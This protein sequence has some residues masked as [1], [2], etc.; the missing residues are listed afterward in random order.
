MK[1]LV[2]N[3]SPSGDNS[4]TLQ[5]VRYIKKLFPEHRYFL[6]NA[7]QRIKS[8]E[9]DFSPAV[10]ALSGADMIVFCYPVYTFLAPAQLHRFIELLKESGTDVSGKC[11]TQITTSKHFYDVTAHRFIMENCMDLGLNYITGLSADMEDLLHEKGQRE[12]EAFFRRTLWAAGN[13]VFE[14][15]NAAP[16]AADRLQRASLPERETVKKDRGRVVIVTD[17]DSSGSALDSM[18]ERFIRVCPYSCSVVNLRDF[19]FAGGC[20]GCFRCA[21][22]GTCIYKD[23]FDV[24]L[25][26]SIQTA[27]ATVYAFTIKDHSMGYRFKLYDDRQF[28]NGH[29]TVTM[30]RPVGYIVDGELSRQPGLRQLMEARAQV[31]GNYLARTACN[32]SDADAAVDMLAR[33]LEYAIENDYRQPADFYGV[34]GLKIFRDLIYTMRGLMREDHRF[35]K[36]HG[37]YDFPQK[38]VGKIAGMYLVGGVMN[39]K[40]LSRKFS[41]EMTGGMLMPYRKVIEKAG[42]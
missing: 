13:G 21:S 19:R 38:Q 29:R 40:K 22:D 37:F 18:T 23:G 16:D 27:D 36:Q 2:V 28:C 31:G 26:D 3:G 7:A 11:A 9:K 15:K 8:L 12:A 25:R 39:S 24:L 20:L 1:I 32:E 4:I 17:S 35:Y 6:L 30:G 33:D 14:E 5:T 10:R 41:S 34:G 42:K